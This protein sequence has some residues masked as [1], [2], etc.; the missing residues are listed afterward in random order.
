MTE[1]MK[2]V[3]GQAE[4]AKN[5]AARAFVLVAL[6]LT[7]AALVAVTLSACSTGVRVPTEA[8]L[9]ATAS[10]QQVVEAAFRYWSAGDGAGAV[11]F[12]WRPH[13]FD[14]LKVDHLRVFRSPK[15]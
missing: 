8:P 12:I 14:T 7:L 9:P 13:V 15:S 10:P 5:G 11:K 4:P 6:T 1:G 3:P 2:V